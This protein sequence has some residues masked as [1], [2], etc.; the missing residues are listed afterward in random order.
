M[1]LHSKQT[2][3][4]NLKKLDNIVEIDNKPL[5][6]LQ[7]PTSLAL[8]VGMQVNKWRIFQEKT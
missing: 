8:I 2:R 4:N 7:N 1:Y 6:G 5:D 3:L